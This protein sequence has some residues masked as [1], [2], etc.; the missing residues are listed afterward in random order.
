MIL[1]DDNFPRIDGKI[2]LMHAIPDAPLVDVY[3]NGKLLYKNLAFAD[4]TKYI[5]VP[6]GTYEIQLY[7]SGE[8]NNLLI[9]ESY[10]VIADSVSTIAVT[11]ANNEI[12]FFVLD[13]SHGICMPEFASVR[14]INLSPDSELLTLRLPENKVLFNE[15]SYLETNEYYPLSAGIYNFIVINADSTFEKYIS[16]IHLKNGTF[17]TIYI[18]GLFKGKPNAGYILLKDK[19]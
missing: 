15:V 3:A 5:N 13:D 17:I 9:T 4:V 16:N 18:I 8:K 11:Y 19:E 10:Q 2:R 1:F 6:A 12:S 7:R 14:F